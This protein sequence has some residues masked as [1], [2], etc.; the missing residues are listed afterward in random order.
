[1]ERFTGFDSGGAGAEQLARA[2]IA[3]ANKPSPPVNYLYTLE[4]SPEEK[5][6]AVAR[7]I[8]GARDLEF[9]RSA[10]QDLE[11]IRHIGCEQ[12]P[13]C[14]AKTHLSLT[15]DPGQIGHPQNFVLPVESVRVAA[16]AV[17]CSP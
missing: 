17:I 6:A 13:V 11:Q 8:Y 5:I 7:T 14:I 12:L 2:V 4:D 16:G 3:A 9:S 15:G 1:M 10:R